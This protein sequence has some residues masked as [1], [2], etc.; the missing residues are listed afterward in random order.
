MVMHCYFAFLWEEL[1]FQLNAN[2]EGEGGTETLLLH[3]STDHGSFVCLEE[4]YLQYKC[5][6]KHKSANGISTDCFLTFKIGS[7]HKPKCFLSLETL[8][9]SDV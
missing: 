3:L 1:T 6:K 5:N 4:I 9:Q 8:T 2:L 7:R